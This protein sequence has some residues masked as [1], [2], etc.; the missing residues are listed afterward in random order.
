[1]KNNNNFD[2][3]I[4]CGGKG[5]RVKKISKGKPKS[6]FNLNNKTK[7]LD[8]IL[9]NINKNKYKF[10]NIY[11]SINKKNI[12]DFSIYK[13]KNKYINLIIE[14]NYLGT[15]GAI[16][17]A[18]KKKKISNPFFVLNGDTLSKASSKLYSFLSISKK[19]FSVIG[20]SKNKK[21]NR[22][23]DIYFIKNKVINFKEKKGKSNWINNGHYL[24]YKKDFETI[25]KKIFSLEKILIP[26]LV[27]IE[28]LY[29]K[30]FNDDSFCDIG[31]IQ[32]FNSFKKRFN[33]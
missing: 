10:K 3:I 8:L 22:F 18:I 25:K 13:K 20:V 32:S 26:K 30:K 23:G 1:M 33:K 15:G 11:L 16:K 31:T 12:A 5:S 6:L 2:V 28:K 21:E 7:I 9:K 4:L 24:F 29:C 17:Y 27:K 14:K 19:E